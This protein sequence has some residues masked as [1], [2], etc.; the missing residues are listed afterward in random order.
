MSKI[1]TEYLAHVSALHP[2][3][4]IGIWLAVFVVAFGILG[5]AVG[6]GFSDALTPEFNQTNNA[7]SVKAQ[8]LIDQKLTGQETVPESIL[9]RSQ[10]L[11]VDDAEF[12]TAVEQLQNDVLATGPEVV[13]S[14]DTFYS[15]GD[16]N[17]V[18][19]DRRST[20]IP[21]S[22]TGTVDDAQK[23][24]EEVYVPVDALDESAEFEVFI[25][26]ETTFAVDFVEQGQKDLEQGE[27]FG[28]PIAFAILVI[29]FGAVVAAFLPIILA[30]GAIILAMAGATVISGS[31]DLHLFTQN[32]ATMIGLAVGIDYSLFIVSRFREERRRGREK[33]DAITVAGGTAARAVFFSGTVVVIALLSMLLIPFTAFVSVGLG[34]ML[35]VI[36]A[37]TATLTLLPAVLSLMGDNVNR[38]AIPG[39]GRFKGSGDVDASG[40]VW[41][42]VSHAVMRRPVVSLVLAGGL[43]VVMTIPLFTIKTGLS[44]VATFPEELRASRGFAA[45]QEDFGFGADAPV[46]IVVEGD[47]DSPAVTGAIEELRATLAGDPDFGPNSLQLGEDGGVALVAAPAVGA[48]QDERAI[49]AVKRVRDEYVPAAFGGVAAD[50]FVGGQTAE[51]IDFTTLAR[52]S[53]PIVLSFVIVLTFLILMVVFR[54]IVVP[55]KAVLLNLLSVGASYGLLVLVFQH[56]WGAEQLGFTESPIIQ[57]WIPLFLF[58]V[59]FGLSMDYHVF[60]LSRIRERYDRTGDNSDSVAFGVRSTAGLITGAALIMVAVFM[61]FTAGELVPFQQMGFGL[62][63]AVF[64]DATIVRV[65]LMPAS[66]QLLGDA[67]WYLPGFLQWLPDVRVEGSEPEFAP[68]PVPAAGSIAGGSE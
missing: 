65:I 38:L 55:L 63:V 68:A 37:M 62:A 19:A 33:I 66:M 30:I 67:N 31:Y 49:E 64:L 53:I 21:V 12:Q 44:G 18:S 5:G 1:S 54:S 43:L 45:L 25:T 23:V 60:L 8:N 26:G 24:I 41:D 11:T 7:G 2:W 36:A 42:K 15:T 28:A 22:M 39:L 20:I 40:G 59:I 56:G 16:E 14:A 10:T 29:V 61:G 3:R 34:A 51:T 58:A 52:E 46:N 47:V 57:A 13:A 35:V 4:V 32:V 50:V 17:L 27:L 6:G 9:V 48:A